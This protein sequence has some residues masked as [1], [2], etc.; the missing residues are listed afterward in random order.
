MET[1]IG[2]QNTARKFP[3]EQRHCQA[4]STDLIGGAPL[5][6]Y[7]PTNQTVHRFL[8]NLIGASKVFQNVINLYCSFK[9]AQPCKSRKISRGKKAAK[10]QIPDPKA[11]GLV[12]IVVYF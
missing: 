7:E 2:L 10:A 12:F 1:D 5:Y 6:S 11:W 9:I 3:A 8:G 4:I